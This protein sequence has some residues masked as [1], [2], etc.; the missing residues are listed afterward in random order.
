MGV[1][2]NIDIWVPVDEY[3][4]VTN[5]ESRQ[6]SFVSSWNTDGSGKGRRFCDSVFNTIG[7]V[8]DT[9]DNIKSNDLKSR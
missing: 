5:T 4:L 2:Q 7:E 3:R 8:I 1:N 6:R 9:Q